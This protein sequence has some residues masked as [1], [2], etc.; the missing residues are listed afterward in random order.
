[1]TIDR[2]SYAND[3]PV[4]LSDH[5]GFSAE[6]CTQNARLERGQVLG[7]STGPEAIAGASATLVFNAQHGQG[8]NIPLGAEI[9][10]GPFEPPTTDPLDIF[11]TYQS[12]VTAVQDAHDSP[13]NITTDLLTFIG[14]GLGVLVRFIFPLP[15]Y[16]N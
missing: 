16:S 7:I 12:G 4:T 11:D 15:A 9:D 3:N 8:S 5:T 2:Y 14:Q 6:P 13:G 1:V 10:L